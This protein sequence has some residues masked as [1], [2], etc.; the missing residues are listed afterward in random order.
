MIANME[1]FQKAIDEFGLE[2]NYSPGQARDAH[3]RWSSGGGKGSLGGQRPSGYAPK[4]KDVSKIKDEQAFYP[5]D[6]VHFTSTVQAL[7]GMGFAATKGEGGSDTT[8]TKVHGE[9]RSSMMYRL[10]EHGWE[11]VASTNSPSLPVDY[12]K[13]TTVAGHKAT[14][15]VTHD[16]YG[17]QTNV[18][19]DYDKV[20]K[21]KAKKATTAA[22]SP[23]KVSSGDIHA[24]LDAA[25][26]NTNNSMFH[27]RVAR[28][29]EVAK[30]DPAKAAGMLE[31]LKANSK[32][33]KNFKDTGKPAAK[34]PEA[35]GTKTTVKKADLSSTQS[36]KKAKV[37]KAP[38]KS[39]MAKDA[40]GITQKFEV[41]QEV[42]FKHDMEQY[43]KILD[44]GPQGIKV[45][46]EDYYDPDY[47]EYAPPVE[48]WFPPSKFWFD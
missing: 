22:S 26:K 38:P 32:H 30:T 18:V 41:G 46:V 6:P 7:G 13:G 19:M 9:T 15:Q 20:K 27:K 8:I 5:K 25:A 10:K 44:I 16:T 35:A 37:T 1:L 28:I 39:I 23:E 47:N 12:Y 34:A 36:V 4:V 45:H 42:A 29:K 2:V 24:T 21:S 3:G 43:S 17:G 14:L 33:A 31:K 11:H 48:M 40:D